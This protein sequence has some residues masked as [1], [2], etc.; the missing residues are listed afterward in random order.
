MLDLAGKDFKTARI[1]MF[2]ESKDIMTKEVKEDMMTLSHQVE[3]S[4]NEMEIKKELH[5]NYEVEK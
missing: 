2:K 1:N 3:N 5:G 4:N